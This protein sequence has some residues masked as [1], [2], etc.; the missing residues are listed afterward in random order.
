[1][2]FAIDPASFRDAFAADLTVEQAAVMAA[3]QRPVA[4]LAFT[5]PSGAPAW[6][7]LPSW[8]VVPTGDKAAGSDVLRSMAERAGATS[9]E[10]EGS[11]VIMM[12]RPQ[13][14]ADLILQAADV[15]RSRPASAAGRS[16]RVPVRAEPAAF[17]RAG[18][19]RGGR[20][21]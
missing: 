20:H 5:E 10:V 21:A 11:H 16:A 19:D 13:V 9:V 3:T 14:V 2:E 4:A 6:R 1:V 7:F 18:P 17:G 8:A 15:V 12:S